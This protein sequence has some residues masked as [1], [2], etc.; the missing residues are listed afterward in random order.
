M[1]AD[2]KAAAPSL[3]IELN[4]VSV[5]TLEEIAVALSAAKRA[6]PQALFPVEDALFTIHRNLIELASNARLLPG[7]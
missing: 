2:L 6:H 1:I 4:F 3:S 7:R 5:R